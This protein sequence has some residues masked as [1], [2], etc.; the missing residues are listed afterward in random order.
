ML[1]CIISQHRP[2]FS[3]ASYSISN[4]RSY[5]RGQTVVTVYSGIEFSGDR[6]MS[7]CVWV[8]AVPLCLLQSASRD[9]SPRALQRTLLVQHHG[10]VLVLHNGRIFVKQTKIVNNDDN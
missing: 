2:A 8:H 7:S 5:S 1:A 3:V 9:S 10:H 4:E 6:V